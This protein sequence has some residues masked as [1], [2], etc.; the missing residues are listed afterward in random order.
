MNSDRN[1]FAALSVATLLS[2][3]GCGQRPYIYVFA[4]VDGTLCD[5]DATVHLHAMVYLDGLGPPPTLLD[6]DAV[7]VTMTLNDQGPANLD[8]NE[9]GHVSK[10]LDSQPGENHLWLSAVYG[11]HP[12]GTSLTYTMAEASDSGTSP[13]PDPR[14]VT[15]A[16]SEAASKGGNETGDSDTGGT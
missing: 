8:P 11:D 6:T 9:F 7:R 4:P 5:S 15:P 10:D 13:D 12:F 16:N 1:C 14:C 3:A 2:I